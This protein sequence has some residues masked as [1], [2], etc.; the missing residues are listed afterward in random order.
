MP[1]RKRALVGPYFREGNVRLSM[2]LR[3]PSGVPLKTVPGWLVS[4]ISE[5]MTGNH[6]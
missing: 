4:R 1:F 5:L 6:R 2:R 3:K